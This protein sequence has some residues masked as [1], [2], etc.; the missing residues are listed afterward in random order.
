M[1]DSNHYWSREI[2][3]GDRHDL[4]GGL[5]ATGSADEIARAAI[6]AAREEGPEDTLERR[7]MSK[8]TFYENRAGRNL[9]DER[10]ATLNEAKEIV[11]DQLS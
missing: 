11:R 5:F 3:E 1:T 10:R 2:T 9:S 6:A 7:A 4:G 8:L